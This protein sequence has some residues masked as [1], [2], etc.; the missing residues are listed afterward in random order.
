MH[1]HVYPLFTHPI[2]DDS[3]VMRGDPEISGL[4]RVA[5]AFPQRRG[6][7]FESRTLGVVSTLE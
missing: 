1:Q 2:M 5:G 3:L 7:G 6:C 4:G